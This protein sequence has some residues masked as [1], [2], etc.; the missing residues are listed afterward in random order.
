MEE[1]E[2]GKEGMCDEERIEEMGKEKE[3]ERTL[4]SFLYP[5]LTPSFI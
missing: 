1:K 4:M 5:S 3:R 2:G